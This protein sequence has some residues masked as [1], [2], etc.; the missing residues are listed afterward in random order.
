MSNLVRKSQVKKL[1]GKN[2]GKDVYDELNKKIVELVAR[3]E[4]R[5]ELNNR[6]TIMAR[7]F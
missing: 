2:I 1:S 6:K 7:D 5:C 3:A 4:K